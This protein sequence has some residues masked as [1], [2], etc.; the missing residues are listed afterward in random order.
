M[1][2]ASPAALP[3]AACAGPV[4]PGRMLPPQQTW[5]AGRAWGQAPV[6]ACHAAGWLI[7]A[8]Q[9]HTRFLRAAGEGKGWQASEELPK[10]QG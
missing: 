1:G 5:L 3:A 10:A 9:E 2:K 7:L 8:L 4:T 6:Q